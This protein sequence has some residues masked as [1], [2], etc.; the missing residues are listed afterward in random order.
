MTPTPTPPFGGILE[1]SL[2]FV[3]KWLFIGALF[4]YVIFALI[5]IQQIK[6]KRD[7]LKTELGPFLEFLAYVH[8]VLSLVV[9]GLA[10]FFL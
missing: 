6:A 10:F 1:S 5:L 8:F 9:F 2:I 7:T 3:Y 4:I